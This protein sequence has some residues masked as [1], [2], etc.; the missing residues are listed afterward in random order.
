MILQCFLIKR[1]QAPVL[2]VQKGGLL[3]K[4]WSHIFKD[5]NMMYRAL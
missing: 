5:L 3:L 4:L 1:V 2:L